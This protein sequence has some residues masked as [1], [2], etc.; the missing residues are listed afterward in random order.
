[1]LSSHKKNLPSFRSRRIPTPF[2]LHQ[3]H[4]QRSVVPFLLPVI[5]STFSK[6]LTPTDTKS[7]LMWCDVTVT[8]RWVSLISDTA[9]AHVVSSAQS[10]ISYNNNS[11]NVFSYQQEYDK[12]LLVLESV[13][14][15]AHFFKYLPTIAVKTHCV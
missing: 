5:Y 2:P 14:H 15:I 1:M 8:S 9:P 6:R 10:I 11:Y 7:W 4:H 3:T 13:R 12:I